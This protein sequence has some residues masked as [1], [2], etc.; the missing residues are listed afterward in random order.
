M[1]SVETMTSAELAALLLFHADAGV[2][3]LVEDGPIDRIAEFAAAK[4]ARGA[5]SRPPPA[6]ENKTTSP[7]AEQRKPPAKAAP[8]TAPRVVIPDGEAVSQARSAAAAAGSLE[9]L[10]A[11]M[12]EFTGCNLRNSAKSL[13]FADGNP[14]TGVMI[15]G[16]QPSAEDDSTLR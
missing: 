9:D 11:A 7:S 3:W 15:V 16:G 14:E 5:V 2:E 12:A 10:R 6:P 13:I 4:A 8:R 1:T